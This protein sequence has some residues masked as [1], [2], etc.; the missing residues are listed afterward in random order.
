[1]ALPRCA[2]FLAVSLDGFIAR[3]DGGLDW[4]DPFRAE[5]GYRDFFGTVD[6]VLAGRGTWE[7]ARAFPE[8]PWAGKRVAVLTHRPLPARHHELVLS[9]APGE[10]L[11]RLRVEGAR[12]VYVDG[13]AVLS[14]FLAADLLDELT[15]NLVPVVLG[16]GIRLFQGDLPERR[17]SLE[18]SR[19]Y[20]SGLV[21]IRY[22]A[23]AAGRRDS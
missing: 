19:A 7:T 10:A 20:P 12:K 9:G 11:A 1:M 14:Q 17:L 2:G 6:W 22:G 16:G 15:V 13:G 4:L 21:Q 23:T 18:S 8:W 5:H 3:R